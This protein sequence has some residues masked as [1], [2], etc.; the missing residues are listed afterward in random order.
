MVEEVRGLLVEAEEET[1]EDEEE[2]R[3]IHSLRQPGL[4][5]MTRARKEEITASVITFRHR[6]TSPTAIATAT[7]T[8]TGSTSPRVTT[9]IAATTA[10]V[11]TSTATATADTTSLP[12]SFA[13]GLHP[14]IERVDDTND[15]IRTHNSADTTNSATI[16][17]SRSSPCNRACR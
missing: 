15:N 1:E 16:I 5:Q 4:I 11:A 6:L 9:A 7:A 8:A 14:A 13:H 10:K 3:V 17:S 2:R 12:P